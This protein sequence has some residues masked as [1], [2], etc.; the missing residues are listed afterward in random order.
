M[1]FVKDLNYDDEDLTNFPDVDP[2]EE[3][4]KG[5]RLRNS[6]SCTWTVSYFIKFSHGNNPDAQMGGQPTSIKGEVEPGEEYDMYVDLVAPEMPGEYVGYWQMH[7]A[8]SK[9]FGQTVWVAVEVRDLSPEEPTATITPEN[10]P[11]PTEELPPEPTDTDIPPEPTA[12]DEPPPEPTATDE[13]P[14]EPTETEEPGADLRDKT[15]ILEGYLANIDD[16][17]PTEPIPDVDLELVFNE[18]GTIEGFAGCNTFSGDYI[19]DGQNL[20][21]QNVLSTQI[22]CGEPEGIMEQEAAFLQLLEDVEEYR[23]NPEDKLEFVREVIEDEQP[24]EKIFMIF[25]E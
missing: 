21:I 17:T 16:E 20:Q 18:G 11:T 1:E 3:F 24:V 19:T 4:Q 12:T 5:W 23:I 14:P 7:N 10:T 2:G 25:Q 22:T 13:L 15:W 8:N 9:P 6:G